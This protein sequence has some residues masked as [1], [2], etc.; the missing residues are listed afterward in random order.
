MTIG[1]RI[2][3]R[4]G[5]I[6]KLYRYPEVRAVSEAVSG[7]IGVSYS[8]AQHAGS[9]LGQWENP[10]NRDRESWNALIPAEQPIAYWWY[11]HRAHW[12]R[13][14][15]ALWYAFEPEDILNP[16]DP[17]TLRMELQGTLFSQFHQV[18]IGGDEDGPSIAP[19]GFDH[20]P[21]SGVF[22]TQWT[23]E[24]DETAAGATRTL[25]VFASRLTQPTRITFVSL[26]CWADS[27]DPSVG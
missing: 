10:I 17:M 15:A 12:T 24:I 16:E 20:Y 13:I 19:N 8:Y 23:M 6:R 2:R 1:D 22:K 3:R 11:V 18:I 25:N 14:N 27:G 9:M 26:S 7:S 21:S 5:P 4:P